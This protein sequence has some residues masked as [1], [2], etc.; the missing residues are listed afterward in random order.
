MM[1]HAG[2][3]LILG[4]MPKL[5]PRKGFTLPEV[6]LATMLLTI[7]IGALASAATFIAV[8]ADDARRMVDATQFGSGVLDS[9]R[10]VPCLSLS[11]GSLVS[12]SATLTWTVTPANQSR[13]IHATLVTTRRSHVR[14]FA[15]DAL[16]PC[17]S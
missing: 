13:G 17:E 16:L 3:A 7:G 14:T 8:E 9:L 12:G 4:P 10:S 6:L 15:L 11:G 1:D 5:R 2:Q